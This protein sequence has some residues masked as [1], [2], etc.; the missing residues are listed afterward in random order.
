MQHNNT[1]HCNSLPA[2][3]TRKPGAR[4]NQHLFVNSRNASNIWGQFPDRAMMAEGSGNAVC[5]GMMDLMFG[6]IHIWAHISLHFKWLSFMLFQQEWQK[7][8]GWIK[9]TALHQSSIWRL[10]SFFLSLFGT[11]FCIKP[12]VKI[13]ALQLWCTHLTSM[14]CNYYIFRS[15]LGIKRICLSRSLFPCLSWCF[16]HCICVTDLSG[17][18]AS[19]SN[20]LYSQLFFSSSPLPL[21]HLHNSRLFSHASSSSHFLGFFFGFWLCFFLLL[22]V[23]VVF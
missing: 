8:Y 23:V 13:Q 14:H 21:L 17:L 10:S 6:S 5:W 22:L 12:E 9:Q 1:L 3:D 4:P 16:L 15:F 2:R 20:S 18:F 19:T 11:E 7:L